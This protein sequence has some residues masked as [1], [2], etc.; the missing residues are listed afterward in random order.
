PKDSA[1]VCHPGGDRSFFEAMLEIEP[2]LIPPDQPAAQHESLERLD[3]AP[4]TEHGRSHHRVPASLHRPAQQAAAKHQIDA[5][6][7]TEAEIASVIEVEI[8][9]HVSG[10]D[11]KTQDRL[12]EDVDAPPEETLREDDDDAKEQQ[13]QL[14][15]NSSTSASLPVSVS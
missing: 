12:A 9:I 8:E 15:S 1:N 13:H 4:I 7:S 14:K 11:A 3:F 5:P 10:P 6:Q 2:L